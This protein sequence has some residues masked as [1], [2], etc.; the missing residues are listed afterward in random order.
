MCTMRDLVRGERA[1]HNGGARIKRQEK[2][3]PP[4]DQHEP[5]RRPC[6]QHD[7]ARLDAE[8]LRMARDRGFEILARLALRKSVTRR[9]TSGARRTRQMSGPRSLVSSH[10]TPRSPR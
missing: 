5:E 7:P 9:A 1:E 3:R 2:F 6:R 4:V 8:L 10:T